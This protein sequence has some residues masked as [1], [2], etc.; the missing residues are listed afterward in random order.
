[1]VRF[2]LLSRNRTRSMVCSIL[3]RFGSTL[4]R[5]GFTEPNLKHVRFGS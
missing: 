5:F 3:I 2:G 1:M 4:G